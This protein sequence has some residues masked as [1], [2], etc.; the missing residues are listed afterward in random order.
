[1]GAAPK[2][3]AAQGAIFD[4]LNDRE[5]S[6]LTQLTNGAKQRM[7]DLPQVMAELQRR[8]SPEQYAALVS[9]RAVVN[10][11][12]AAQLMDLLGMRQQEK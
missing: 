6:A 12:P 8:L 2:G 4:A 11:D 9:D 10:S 5:R 3:S 1:M 7:P